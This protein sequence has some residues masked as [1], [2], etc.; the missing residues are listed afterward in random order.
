MTEEV[1]GI[2]EEW[3]KVKSILQDASEKTLGYKKSKERAE[4][5]SGRTLKLMDNR[6]EYKSRRRESANMAKQHNYFSRM[7]KRSAKEDKEELIRGIR[8]EVE[9]SRANNKTRAV[10]EG[11]RRITQTHAPGLGTVKGE[12]GGVLNEPTE[13]RK[14][15]KEY[16]DKLYN[17]P[18]EVDEEYLANID[19]RRNYE[20]IPDLGEDEVE[21]AIRKLKQRK[22]TEPDNITTEELQ[23]GT[24]GVGVRAMHRLCQAVWDKEELPAQWKR[25]IIIPIHKKK[26]RLERANY[27]GISLTCH[28][29]RA[30][31]VFV[32]IPI[33]S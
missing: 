23:P 26:D 28:K 11:I 18:S 3:S 1:E 8:Y 14:R 6:R 27:R 30:V 9:N 24:D 5:I 31:Y 25:S 22:A 7:V 10:Y 19:E 16:F 17:D 32:L 21:A 33:I 4:W 20:D 13:V 29:T 12:N 15:W 2:E